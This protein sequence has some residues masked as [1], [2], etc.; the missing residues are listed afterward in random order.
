MTRIILALAA[1]GLLAACDRNE[2]A[3]S[4]AQSTPPSAGTSSSAGASQSAPST[5]ANAGAPTQ[6]EKR[7]G[8]NPTQQQ[9]DPKEGVQHRD[10]Q[11]NEDGK[12]PRSADT[13]PRN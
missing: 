13:K 6:E 12:G 5:P 10:F 4:A 7:E 2:P 11:N 9:I 3:S 8:A 1:A